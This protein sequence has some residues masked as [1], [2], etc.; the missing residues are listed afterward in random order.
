MCVNGS[1]TLHKGVWSS[2]G[3]VAFEL[4]FR[5]ESGQI[6]PTMQKAGI[7]C[8]EYVNGGDTLDR[9]YACWARVGVR[10]PQPP[11]L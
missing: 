3:V 6:R 8:M 10:G 9:R 2:C 4:G 5:V 11:N 1:D 7:F